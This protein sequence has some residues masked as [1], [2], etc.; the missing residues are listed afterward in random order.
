MTENHQCV[1]CDSPIENGDPFARVP[2]PHLDDHD[3]IVIHEAC[4]LTGR[5]DTV[6]MT[7]DGDHGGEFNHDR[8]GEWDWDD[9]SP[10]KPDK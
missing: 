10:I 5:K 3:V 8:D 9:N 7:P 2:T 6:G 4:M 1:R